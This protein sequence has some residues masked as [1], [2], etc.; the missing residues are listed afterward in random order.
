[1][2]MSF[3]DIVPWALSCV[4]LGFMSLSSGVSN[5]ALPWNRPL[6]FPNIGTSLRADV[7]CLNTSEYSTLSMFTSPL[8]LGGAAS[9]AYSPLSVI[10]PPIEFSDMPFIL[11]LPLLIVNCPLAF[12]MSILSKVMWLNV[13]AIVR[14]MS[15]GSTITLLVF[16]PLALLLSWLCA[17]SAVVSRSEMLRYDDVVLRLPFSV[18][19]WNMYE[20]TL[21]R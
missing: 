20:I 14:F 10:V 3:D 13:D 18:S 7:I 19:F 5:V 2:D 16:L 21:S 11:S 9:D 6:V 8:S 15:C 12:V 1:M 4:R 17:P